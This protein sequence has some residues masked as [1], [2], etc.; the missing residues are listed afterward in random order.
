MPFRA[1]DRH[2]NKGH[3]CGVRIAAAIVVLI[4][5]VGG[6]SAGTTPVTVSGTLTLSGGPPPG[7]PRP[8]PNIRVVARPRSS[9]HSGRSTRTDTSGEWSLRLVPGD[10]ELASGDGCARK[11]V[12]VQSGHPVSGIRLNCAVP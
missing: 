11:Q 3:P 4:V 2:V 9:G 12:T 7:T 8:E 10:W 1:G 5:F 6:C